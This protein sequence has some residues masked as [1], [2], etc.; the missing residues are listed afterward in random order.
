MVKR[1]ICFTGCVVHFIFS[2]LLVLWVGIYPNLSS[3]KI[4]II[5]DILLVI[6]SLLLGTAFLRLNTDKLL[7]KQELDGFCSLD[8][9]VLITGGILAL[10]VVIFETAMV[11][12]Y[13][14]RGIKMAASEF[15]RF[16]VLPLLSLMH[17]GV[18]TGSYFG[19]QYFITYDQ[20]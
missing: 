11:L 1:W 3:A 4:M 19:L 14:L 20:V 7:L 15:I 12:F 5:S 18:G 6:L 8:K 17:F 13:F 10:L 9:A 16:I 2:A